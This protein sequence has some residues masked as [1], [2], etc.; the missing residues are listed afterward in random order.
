MK[1]CRL[2]SST[3]ITLCCLIFG[4]N[5]LRGQGNPPGSLRLSEP[6]FQNH[7]SALDVPYS[8][9]RVWDKGY[10]ISY[11]FDGTYQSSPSKP[12]ILIYDR[13]GRLLHQETVWFNEAERVSIGDVAVSKAGKVI[14]SGGTHNHAGAVANFIAEMGDSGRVERVI[15]TTPFR[16]IYICAADDRTVWS[17]GF[18]RDEKLEDVPSSLR[19]R[20]FSFDKGQVQAMLGGLKPD[21]PHWAMRGKH[22]N[23][24]SMRC[25][26]KRVVLYNASASEWVEFDIP[27]G[28]LKVSKV[29]P[30]PDDAG[31]RV[32]GFAITESGDVFISLQSVQSLIPVQAYFSS[33]LTLMVWG[34]GSPL[35]VARE[36]FFK[37]L[38]SRNFLGPMTTS[39]FTP[40]NL[41]ERH[42][43]QSIQSEPG[44]LALRSLRV[45][46]SFRLLSPAGT[47]RHRVAAWGR[48]TDRDRALGGAA[49]QPELGC[50]R[51]A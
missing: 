7:F 21:T 48:R 6:H 32:T 16:P 18:D 43:G 44:R 38:K 42:T 5:G 15:R 1:N 9:A 39:W 34:S 30:L 51:P 35:K 50:L 41:T 31:M 28:K 36:Y 11:A 20:Q 24:I 27:T 49:F 4:T 47:S 12:A 25:T 2:V 26:S 46:F 13:A 8:G 14:V 45:L 23:D 29:T 10:L 40:V 33:Y 17:Y 22:P 37:E 3:F 19:L